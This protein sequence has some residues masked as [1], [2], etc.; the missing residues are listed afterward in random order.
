MGRE[1]A[2]SRLVVE[3]RKNK[4]GQVGRAPR[5]G[6]CTPMLQAW[7]PFS[8]AP[9]APLTSHSQYSIYLPVLYQ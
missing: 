6:L 2:S 4:G 5:R 1:G 7:E 8:R 9:T 3:W